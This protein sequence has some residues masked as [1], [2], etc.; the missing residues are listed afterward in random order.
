MYFFPPHVWNYSVYILHYFSNKKG[1]AKVTF[2]RT[3]QNI[4]PIA[5]NNLP[6][7]QKAGS[8]NGRSWD[9]AN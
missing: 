1:G 8:Y 6:L 7:G 4:L 9:L 3:A 2:G 5:K